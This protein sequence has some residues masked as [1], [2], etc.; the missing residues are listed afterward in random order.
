MNGKQSLSPAIKRTLFS[1]TN[2]VHF[3]EIL[4]WLLSKKTRWVQSKILVLIINFFFL[5]C[6][7]IERERGWVLAKT[8]VPWGRGGMLENKHGQTRG[9]GGGSKLGN[10]KR[11]Y[12]LNVPWLVGYVEK[13]LDKKAKTNCK[14]Y[15]FTDS[16]TNNCNTHVTQYRVAVVA[17]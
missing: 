6:T 9:E 16:A 8:N 5:N 15:N 4:L 3:I 1:C 17:F 2:G 10:L 14:T 13:R 11:T 12:F 7:S